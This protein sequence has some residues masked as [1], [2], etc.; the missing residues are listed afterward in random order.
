M[1]KAL[2]IQLPVPQLNFGHRTGNIPFAAA[3]LKEAAGHIPGTETL[4][5]PQLSASYMGDAALAESEAMRL[6]ATA[7]SD[8]GRVRKT[9]Q[10]SVGCFDELSLYLLSDGMGG[11]KD[12]EIASRLAIDVIRD[13]VAQGTNGNGPTRDDLGVLRAAIARAVIS[14]PQL[15]LA[16]E[17]TGN[18][19]S[20][21]SEVV[22]EALRDAWRGTGTTVV[23]VTHD[24]ELAGRMDRVLY[25]SDGRLATE[26]APA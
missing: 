8:I 12:G 25:L 9:N 22:L 24:R 16:D 26:A 20:E 15:L 21:A 14:R 18:L 5:F 19:D 1:I 13:R 10:D 23:L 17:P 6:T 2:L 3:C 7:V 11:L 4:L